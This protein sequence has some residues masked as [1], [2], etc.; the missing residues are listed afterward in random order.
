MPAHKSY[1]W[2]AEPETELALDQGRQ[3][4][5]WAMRLGSMPAV[6]RSLWWLV[7]LC[8][9][10][11]LVSM[12][13]IGSGLRTV[14]QETMAQNV[15]LIGR[16]VDA[17][18]KDF[19]IGDLLSGDSQTAALLR[20]SIQAVLPDANDLS[21][22]SIIDSQGKVIVSD[23]VAL[24]GKRNLLPDK[25]FT[26]N[27]E[28]QFFSS[29][30]GLF[31]RGTYGIRTPLVESG[32][33][34][35]YIQL[36]L[37]DKLIKPWIEMV[38]ERLPLLLLISFAILVAIGL[39]FQRRLA[40]TQ[41]RL[42]TGINDL[43]QNNAVQAF[44]DNRAVDQIDQAMHTLTRTFKTQQARAESYRAELAIVANRLETGLLQLDPA[45]QIQW[46][47]TEMART[48]LSSDSPVRCNG[49]Q[50]PNLQ[51]FLQTIVR[52]DE[53][54]SC[55]ELDL[56]SEDE[57]R[58]LQVELI[59]LAVSDSNGYMAI[60][61]DLR[62]QEALQVDLRDALRFRSLSALYA[63]TV[64]DL[65]GPMNNIVVHL[66]LLK[67]GLK[68]TAAPQDNT[69]R[70]NDLQRRAIDIIQQEI[71]RLNRYVQSLLD[72]SAP[73]QDNSPEI[74]IVQA[75]KKLADPIA[76]QAKQQRVQL[77]WQMP[78]QP[79]YVACRQLEFRQLVLN[80]V[81]NALEAMPSDG[82]LTVQLRQED[83]FAII[84]IKDTGPGIEPDLQA[85]I[86]DMH[87]STKEHASGVGLYVAQTV[88]SS[89]GGAIE[90]QSTPGQGSCFTIRL[91]ALS[92]AAV[93]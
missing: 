30:E 32:R 50:Y 44:V 93:S 47:D 14:A 62:K 70:A 38:Y 2:G 16:A 49:E 81:I 45:G 43:T 21:A 11:A 15:Q 55:F 23:D 77:D 84:D 82:K 51:A 67:Q 75:L 68:L 10:L 71:H 36:R 24:I 7:L 79:V 12:I 39:I 22:I 74:E 9:V 91:P 92:E 48:I 65:R 1:L 4:A 31:D 85:R 26:D 88:A 60:L 54:N 6:V 53:K 37:D 64:H 57:Q 89:L 20:Q 56:G 90:L 8:L 34:V 42:V 40:N 63:G 66:E 87:F 13:W 19:T 29:Y 46:A 33:V 25:I 41:R 59:P 72:L 83:A 80:L 58:R 52:H 28:A 78:N 61:Q 35:G 18:V 27:R 73:C 17:A 76:A 3:R 86:F 5:P 69:S